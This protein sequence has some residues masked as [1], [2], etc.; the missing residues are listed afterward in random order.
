M[1]KHGR[2]VE[3]DALRGLAIIL[4]CLFHFSMMY[5]KSFLPLALFKYGATGVDL[6]FMISGF[7]IFMSIEGSNNVKKFWLLRFNRLFP[8]YWLSIIIAVVV[9]LFLNHGNIVTN[10]KFIIG[11]LFMIQPALNTPSLVDAYWTLYVEL[12]FY[13]LISSIWFFGWINKIEGII[14]M[15]LFLMLLINGL[16]VLTG[17]KSAVFLRFFIASRALIP[18]LSY[19]CFFASGII[20][21]KIYQYGWT[22]NRLLLLIICFIMTALIHNISGRFNLF[23]GTIERL[24]CVAIFNILFI[25]FV[26]GK[27][28]FLNIRWLLYAGA[29]SYALYLVHESFG[30]SLTMALCNKI[31]L[32]LAII[33]GILASLVLSA[34]I[35]VLFEKPIQ[36]W[37]KKVQSK[38]KN[39]N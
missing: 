25:L 14:W 18:M 31:N 19:F 37:L 33:L 35:T 11:N 30:L 1:K 29:I 32:S 38:V 8:A 39:Y 15:G 24:F 3:L 13:F 10:W 2:I 17:T 34:L 5:P 12:S 28:A 22:T 6:F 4:V 36:R 7:V 23:F 26:N 21:S 20:Y 16:Y 9:I 27:A